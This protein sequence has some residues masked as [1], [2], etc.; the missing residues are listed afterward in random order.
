MLLQDRATK[1]KKK[2]YIFS[3]HRPTFHNKRK[4]ASKNGRARDPII[5]AARLKITS[6]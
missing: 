4:H 5:P 1:K 6:K 2:K 3:I